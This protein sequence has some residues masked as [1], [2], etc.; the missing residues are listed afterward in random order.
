MNRH[1]L[2]LERV[3]TSVSTTKHIIRPKEKVRGCLIAL[4]K[5]GRR[6][7]QEQGEGGNVREEAEEVDVHPHCLLLPHLLDHPLR[8]QLHHQLHRYHR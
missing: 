8:F 1:L 5:N 3:V 6:K 7:D 2:I 4:E